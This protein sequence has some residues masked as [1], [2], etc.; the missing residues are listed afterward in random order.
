MI[1]WTERY[2][3][4][5]TLVVFAIGLM[6]MYACHPANAHD[7]SKPELDKWF[8][9]LSSKQGGLCCNGREAKELDDSEAASSVL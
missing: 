4:A 9:G 6:A 5:L 2:K 3:V 1:W 7:L 8:Q